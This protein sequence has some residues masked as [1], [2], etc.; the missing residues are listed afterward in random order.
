MNDL[1]ELKTLIR[2]ELDL[3]DE[4]AT[5]LVCKMAK[6]DYTKTEKYIIEKVTNGKSINSS[7]TEIEREYNPNFVND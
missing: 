1:K 5:P 3:C 7:I 6:T 2:T 4:E